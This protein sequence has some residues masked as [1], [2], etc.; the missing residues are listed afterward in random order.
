MRNI[1]FRLLFVLI[2]VSLFATARLNVWV[3]D[4]IGAINLK[5]K[6][7]LGARKERCH[8]VIKPQGCEGVIGVS[9][10]GCEDANSLRVQGC[11]GVWV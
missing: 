9:F 6:R 1:A 3:H 5:A 7:C 2:S 10:L 11:V 4:F 8:D